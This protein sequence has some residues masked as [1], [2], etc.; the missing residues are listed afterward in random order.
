M[1]SVFRGF[2]KIC[3]V[4]TSIFRVMVERTLAPFIIQ[5]GGTWPS[6]VVAAGLLTSTLVHD[7]SPDKTRHT[8]LSPFLSLPTLL[9]VIFSNNR[10]FLNGEVQN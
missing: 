10:I 6:V 9:F 8:G 1:H 2:R 4:K 3:S 7:V 5:A